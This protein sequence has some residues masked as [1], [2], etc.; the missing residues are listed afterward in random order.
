MNGK[1]NMSLNRAQQNY[2]E[3][4]RFAANGLLHYVPGNGPHEAIVVA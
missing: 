4:L 3:R 1:P 2:D